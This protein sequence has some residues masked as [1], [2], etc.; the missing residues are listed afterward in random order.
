MTLGEHLKQAREDNNLSLRA[1]EKRTGISNAFLSQLESG[2]VKQPSPLVLHKLATLYS[3]EYETLMDATGY[4]VPKPQQ[5]YD[6]HVL[7]R[8][9]KV[10]PAE[11]NELT[12]YLAF[13]RSRQHNGRRQR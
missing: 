3:I 6:N 10:T 2:K 11:E 1:V 7:G 5:K 8:L 12:G 13:I 9:G 4:P